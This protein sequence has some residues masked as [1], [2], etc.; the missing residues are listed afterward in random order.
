MNLIKLLS[1]VVILFVGC[2][3]SVNSNLI[4]AIESGDPE[5]VRRLL[6]EGASPS[7][8]NSEG[9][10]VLIVAIELRSAEIV[11]LLL[12]N[13]ADVNARDEK[14]GSTALMVAAFSGNNGIFQMLLDHGADVNATAGISNATALG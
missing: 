14:T 3:Q 7:T 11:K 5:K 8:K 1:V 12:D 4:T 13:K 2:A 6:A 10:P 9:K